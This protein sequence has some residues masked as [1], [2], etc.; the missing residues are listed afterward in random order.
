MP[1]TDNPSGHSLLRHTTSEQPELF[2][3]ALSGGDDH[4]G[5]LDSISRFLDAGIVT[6]AL[7]ILK[8]AAPTP[9][10]TELAEAVAELSTGR[11][12]DGMV[13]TLGRRTQTMMGKQGG[14]CLAGGVIGE[15]ERGVRVRLD[16][17]PRLA[18][19]LDAFGART[20]RWQ[21]HRSALQVATRKE[22]FDLGLTDRPSG[23]HAFTGSCATST[24]V[25][26]DALICLTKASPGSAHCLAD[27]TKSGP[28]QE[29]DL[30][31]QGRQRH[32]EPLARSLT[33]YS[34]WGCMYSHIS[35]SA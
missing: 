33:P 10:R 18:N 30:A 27:R 12:F 21:R 16:R 6:G 24:S 26:A 20:C 34:A 1:L 31:V 23:H 2:N 22:C 15:H 4:L 3:E 17:R 9:Q 8:L 11:A 5:L 29:N 32:T 28:V 7:R 35:S 19:V 25:W 14:Q 13:A